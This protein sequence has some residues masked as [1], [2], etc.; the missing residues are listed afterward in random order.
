M[1]SIQTRNSL[2]QDLRFA[3]LRVTEVHRLVHKLVHHDEVVADALLLQLA[4]V[5]LE[6]LSRTLKRVFCVK[7]WS[8]YN[9]IFTEALPW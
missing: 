4:E 8:V 1:D 2:S 9:Q 7:D 5:V 3:G 6:H